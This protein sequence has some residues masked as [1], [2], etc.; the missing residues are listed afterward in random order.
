M[1]KSKTAISKEVVII[2]ILKE[3][4]VY[5]VAGWFNEVQDGHRTEESYEAMTTDDDLMSLADWSLQEAYKDGVLRSESSNRAIEAKHIKFLGN[6][7]IGKMKEVAV[8]LA[9]IDLD[10]V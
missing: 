8:N 10:L 5:E 4:I 1:A 6:E 7:F 2:T 3:N 9:K